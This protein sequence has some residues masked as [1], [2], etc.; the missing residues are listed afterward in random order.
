MKR[1][2]RLEIHR[3]IFA[4]MYHFF[5]STQAAIE[6][7]SFIKMLQSIAC[8]EHASNSFRVECDECCIFI[9]FIKLNH[10]PKTSN[11]NQCN[12]ISFNCFSYFQLNAVSS[13]KLEIEK[14]SS[15]MPRHN[16]IHILHR[17]VY[18]PN[19]EGFGALSI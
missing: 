14:D 4:L 2:Q 17:F 13:Y 11:P 3:R 10:E 12:K 7:R 8:T 16:Q 18:H 6:F 5:L 9:H 15:D 19:L 1:E